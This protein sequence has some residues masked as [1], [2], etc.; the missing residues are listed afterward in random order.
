[1]KWLHEF[2]TQRSFCVRVGST[3][4]NWCNINKG[5]PQGT[6]LGPILYNAATAEL[7]NLVL[8]EGSSIILYADDL[9]L[10][11]S[12]PSQKE[13]HNLQIDC[14]R[15]DAFYK[16]EDLKLNGSKT[17]FLLVSVAPGGAA[18]LQTSISVAGTDIT[19]SE[20]LKY[21]GITLDARLSFVKHAS[22]IS[23]KARK[24]LGAVRRILQR[25][26]LLKQID[27]IYTMCIRPIVTYGV[28]ITYPRTKEGRRI[29]ERINRIAS[30]M[31]L[32]RYDLPY[33]DVLDSLKWDSIQWISI[34]ERLR[35]MYLSNIRF[36]NG[37]ENLI[38]K[39]SSRRSQRN[40]NDLQFVVRGKTPSLKRSKNS[41]I[42]QM[43]RQWNKLPSTTVQ[44]P[45]NRFIREITEQHIKALLI[46]E[47]I[48]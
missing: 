3:Y 25:W 29:L 31:T 12:L 38:T 1:M 16:E 15:I 17:Q 5:V 47:D 24:M 7:K 43:V 20:E 44:L 28:A 37:S 45:Y 48:L 21:L 23:G 6:V 34:K 11:K 36:Q 42:Q 35:L 19:C 8:T 33:D 10:V 14:Q 9:L 26:N 13:E 46:Q 18:P 41:T 30:N 4:S 32:N 22:K 39:E 40:K 2:L 27:R